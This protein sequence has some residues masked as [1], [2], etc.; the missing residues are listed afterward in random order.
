MGLFTKRYNATHTCINDLM[1]DQTEKDVVYRTVN[2]QFDKR[3]LFVR[4][5]TNILLIALMPVNRLWKYEYKFMALYMNRLSWWRHQMEKF[6]R[7]WP[8]VR[9]TH[10]SPVHSSHKGQWRGALIF[11]SLIC[12]WMNYWV[13]TRKAGDLRRHR[14]HYDVTVMM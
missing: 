13:N 8:F 2:P 12:A 10:R 7:Y 14:V 9:G 1:G 4:Y 5:L 3:K 11:S 6:P